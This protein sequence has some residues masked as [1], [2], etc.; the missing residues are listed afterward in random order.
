MSRKRSLPANHSTI[1]STQTT[2]ASDA[3]TTVRVRARPIQPASS[4]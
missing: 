1:T 4:N 3:S 2:T